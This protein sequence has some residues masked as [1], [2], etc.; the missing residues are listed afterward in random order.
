MEQHGNIRDF[1]SFLFW[2]A[3]K[4]MEQNYGGHGWQSFALEIG[5]VVS[6]FESYEIWRLTGFSADL[7]FLSLFD[8]WV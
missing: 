2:G 1:E 4:N 5:V 7:G 6:G 8:I 3:C